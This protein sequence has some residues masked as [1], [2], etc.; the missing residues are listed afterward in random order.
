MPMI[1]LGALTKAML[2]EAVGRLQKQKRDTYTIH[3]SEVA[4]A[5]ELDPVWTRKALRQL[6]ED[7]LI[8]FIGVWRFQVKE[9]PETARNH[10]SNAMQILIGAF[11]DTP[12]FTQQCVND[13]MARL[14]RALEVM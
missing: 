14:R 9:L 13:A 11:T 5:L 1:P 2:L 7:G 4:R 12:E 10:V 8:D 6:E 3:A